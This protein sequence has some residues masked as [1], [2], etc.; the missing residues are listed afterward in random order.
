VIKKTN[1]EKPSKIIEKKTEHTKEN[2]YA[3]NSTHIIGTMPAWLIDDPQEDQELD[4]K[5]PEL[6]QRSY[7]EDTA[8]VLKLADEVPGQPKLPN[9]SYLE[10]AAFVSKLDSELFP[11]SPHLPAQ[12]SRLPELPGRRYLEDGDFEMESDIVHPSKTPPRHSE[13][14]CSP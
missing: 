4:D 3:P 10:D 6:P 12:D 7:M 5:V 14:S 11:D 2:P 8:F 1:R 9:R 13:T